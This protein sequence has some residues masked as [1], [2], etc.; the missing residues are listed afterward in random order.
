MAGNKQG[1]DVALYWPEF[2][3]R[4]G[5]DT[6]G[7]LRTA[8]LHATDAIV[9]N[10]DGTYTFNFV[11]GSEVTIGANEITGITF[12]QTTGVVTV[13]HSN[14]E[15]DTFTI[16]VILSAAANDD[17]TITFTFNTG[18]QITTTGSLI[19]PQG[20]QGVSQF[21]VF[22]VAATNNP[23]TRP[24][25]TIF[26]LD[27]DFAPANGIPTGW[28]LTPDSHDPGESLF[29]I[30]AITDPANDDPDGDGNVLLTWSNVFIAGSTGPSGP[31]GVSIIG[32]DVPAGRS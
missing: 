11:D 26:E 16:P 12:N 28:T 10:D 4:D 19:G 27:E 21:T 17:G 14:K 25:P 22:Q 29:A 32:V 7:T 31:A 9:D 5:Y 1:I 24:N 20:A 15:D 3:L 30:T 23:P 2:I 6:G 8:L 18:H 13:Q